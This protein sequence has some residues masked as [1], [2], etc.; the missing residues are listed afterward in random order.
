[1]KWRITS[2]LIFLT[3]FLTSC[4]AGT[5]G[6]NRDIL[7]GP[8]KISGTYDLILIGGTFPD[9]PDRLVIFDIPGDGHEFQPVTDKFRIKR[10]PGLPAQAALEKT[11]GFFSEHCAYNGFA[12]K[13]LALPSGES[14]GYE[15]LPDYPTILCEYGNEIRVSYGEEENGVIKVSTWLWI[16]KH[17][18]QRRK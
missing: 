11:R 5:A 15:L 10:I 2:I 8:E 6:L 7:S 17:E 13:S 3:F 16:R 18:N 9:D 12:T 4:L 14:V 1:M